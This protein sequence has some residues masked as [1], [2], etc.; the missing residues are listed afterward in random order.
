MADQFNKSVTA[1]AASGGNIVLGFLGGLFAAVAGALIWMGVAVGLNMHLGL[2][3]ILIGFM[4]GFAIRFAG[5]GSNPIFGIMGAVLTLVGCFAGD[6]LAMT[7]ASVSEQ[8]DFFNL[9]LST[10]VVARVTYIVTHLDPMGYLI[11]GIAVFEGYKFSMR[12]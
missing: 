11:Y 12:K 9:L 8:H 6:I 5:H 10:D 3:A 7:Y 2:V 1:D 4:V